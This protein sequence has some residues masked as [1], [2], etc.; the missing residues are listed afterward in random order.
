MSS[1]TKVDNNVWPDKDPSV[2]TENINYVSVDSYVSLAKWN[3]YAQVGTDKVE[4]RTSW[5]GGWPIEEVT[6][7]FACSNNIDDDND[8]LIDYPNDPGCSSSSDDD[9]YNAPQIPPTP[10][11]LTATVVSG[12]SVR[13]DWDDVNG[14]SSYK[15]ERSISSLGFWTEIGIVGADITTYTDIGLTASTTYY[16]RIKAVNSAGSS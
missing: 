9:E 6:P 1:F 11:G 12:S 8:G 13:L 14:E 10:T 7:V 16:Y 4:D 15:I 5:D 3:N 2:S